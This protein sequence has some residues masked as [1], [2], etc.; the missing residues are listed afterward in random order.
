MSLALPIF[1]PPFR[2]FFAVAF[3]FAVF[4]LPAMRLGVEWVLRDTGLLQWSSCVYSGMRM[5]MSLVLPIFFPPFRVFFAP[6]LDFAA[7]AFFFAAMRF[8]FLGLN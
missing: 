2:V 1:F 3:G 8:S 7:A 5:P 6:A 4:F